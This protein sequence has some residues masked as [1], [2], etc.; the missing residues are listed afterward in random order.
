MRVHKACFLLH[1]LC[2]LFLLVGF[3]GAAELKFN[4]QDFAPYNYELK[5]VVAGPAADVVRRICAEMKIDCPMRLLSWKRAQEEVNNGTAQGLFVVAWNKA[6]AKTLF[7][8]PPLVSVEYGFF[9]RDDNPLKFKLDSDVKGYR[10][11]VFGP[12]NTSDALEQIKAE[13]KELTIDMTPDDES[14][15]RK[16]S[17]GRV[18]AVFSNREVGYELARTLNL[19]NLRYAGRQQRL[20]YYIGFSQR[21]TDKKLVDQFNAVFRDLHKRGVIKEILGKY[22]MQVAQLE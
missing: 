10:V 22:D 21:F 2:G 19:K 14:A 18:D 4:T 8:S 1:A 6:R 12:S 11:G 15:F 9:V 3:A 16:L 5:G 17:A 20:K 7:F 13:I